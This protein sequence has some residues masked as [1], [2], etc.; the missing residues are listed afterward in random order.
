MMTQQSVQLRETLQLKIHRFRL[1]SCLV[2]GTSSLTYTSIFSIIPCQKT[3]A[4]QQH[5][6]QY[7]L[8]NT[9]VFATVKGRNG[10]T[11]VIFV[12]WGNESD[13]TGVTFM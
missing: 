10:T 8:T 2:I 11:R 5:P 1:Q 6:V 3:L 12:V 7:K 13:S 4:K 9:V